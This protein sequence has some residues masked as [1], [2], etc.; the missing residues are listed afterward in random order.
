MKPLEPKPP[1]YEERAHAN[2][3]R[4]CTQTPLG[5][6][7]KGLVHGC[8]ETGGQVTVHTLITVSH[9]NLLVPAAAIFVTKDGPL[10]VLGE[11]LVFEPYEAMKVRARERPTRGRDSGRCTVAATQAT[12]G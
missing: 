8:P 3:R 5:I 2:R 9:V 4:L 11:K 6:D 1:G 12:A 10:D 7:V